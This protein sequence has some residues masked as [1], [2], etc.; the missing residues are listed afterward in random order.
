MHLKTIILLLGAINALNVAVQTTMGEQPPITNLPLSPIS[1]ANPAAKKP[2]ELLSIT[3]VATVVTIVNSPK[4]KELSAALASPGKPGVVARNVVAKHLGLTEAV[5]KSEYVSALTKT[6]HVYF[7]QYIGGIEVTNGNIGVTVADSGL[8]IAYSDVSFKA[9]KAKLAPWQ[10]T[11]KELQEAQLA[12]ISLP[13]SPPPV[14]LAIE[15]QKRADKSASFVIKDPIVTRQVYIINEEYNA[16]PAWRVNVQVGPH[17]FIIHVTADGKAVL[18]F[19]KREYSASYSVVPLG[20]SDATSAKQLV[21]VVNPHDP[22]AS[23]NGWH[24]LNGRP[25]QELQGSNAY[26]RII[27]DLEKGKTVTA[28]SATD[29]YIYPF[30]PNG[31]VQA[32][33]QAALSSVFYHVNIMHDINVNYGFT[34]STGNFE[35]GTGTYPDGKPRND[36]IEVTLQDPR[37]PD[38]AMFGTAEYGE[39]SQLR[40]GVSTGSGKAYDY[41]FDNDIII[42][43]ITHGTTDRLVGG[44]TEDQCLKQKLGIGMSEGY[45]DFAALWTRFAKADEAKQV[46]LHFGTYTNSNPDKSKNPLNASI[47][48]GLMYPEVH[49][50]GNLWGNILYQ[51]P[52]THDFRTPQLDKSNTLVMFMVMFSLTILPCDPTF[53]DGREALLAA[54]ITI[55]KGAYYCEVYAAFAKYGLGEGAGQPKL[56]GRIT[57]SDKLP[58]ACATRTD[59]MN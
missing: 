58:A 14:N 10:F 47:L 22:K 45:S 59:L 16:I 20:Y 33:E 34:P 9:N 38:N 39:P 2:M 19:A 44:Y 55:T 52:V 35:S 30:D 6:A 11:F 50:M 37:S 4:L 27:R 43:E 54:E 56:F 5:V 13:V 8:I 42:H 32:N 49:D 26:V 24:S 46:D 41:S 15:P 36:R 31:S 7:K 53:V 23:P 28:N 18:T 21:K 48:N 40:V 1:N 25:T 17:P 12:L 3:P 29:D 57:L 51:L